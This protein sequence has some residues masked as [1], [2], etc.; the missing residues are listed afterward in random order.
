MLPAMGSPDNTLDDFPA[1]TFT[2]LAFCDTC[3]YQA[4]LDR[5]RVPAGVTVQALRMRLRCSACGSR[6]TSLRILYTGAGGFRYGETTATG[7]VRVEGPLNQATTVQARPGT[8]DHG[9]TLHDSRQKTSS[10]G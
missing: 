8:S 10:R 1:E 9:S 4:P 7:D 5:N 6:A 3:G 2:I